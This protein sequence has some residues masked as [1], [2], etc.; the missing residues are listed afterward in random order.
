ME[1]GREGGRRERENSPVLLKCY[2]ACLNDNFLLAFQLSLARII[3]HTC[4]I[5]NIVSRML[6]LRS[7]YIKH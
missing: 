3:V 4:L 6:R 7:G 5:R 2:G 1:G